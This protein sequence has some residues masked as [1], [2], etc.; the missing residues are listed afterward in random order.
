MAV[1]DKHSSNVAMSRA[2][3][4]GTGRILLASEIAEFGDSWP[5][6]LACYTI[7][8]GALVHPVAEI[9]RTEKTHGRAAYFARSPPV[10]ADPTITART[11]Y[12]TSPRSSRSS[13][14]TVVGSCVGSGR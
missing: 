8:C 11:V 4:S 10:V 1:A 14:S 6:P 5:K 13:P 9:P 3:H 12:T 7:E 2:R